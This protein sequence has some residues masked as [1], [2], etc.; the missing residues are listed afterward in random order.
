MSI[1]NSEKKLE[2]KVREVL[3]NFLSPNHVNVLLEKRIKGRWNSDEKLS[4][5]FTKKQIQSSVNFEKLIVFFY[6]CLFMS[7]NSYLALIMA[8]QL[9]KE[10]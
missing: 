8:Y 2:I 1:I 6:R 10:K 4:K 5:A 9:N 7:F 3:A